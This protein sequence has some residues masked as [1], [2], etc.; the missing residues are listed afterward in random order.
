MR[1]RKRMAGE[2]ARDEPISDSVVKFKVNVYFTL[3]DTLVGELRSRFS[4]FQTM[5]VPFKCLMPGHLH[6][7]EGFDNLASMYED[8]VDK[9]IANAEYSQ[10]CHF[11]DITPEFVDDPP[12]IV[13][14]MLHMINRWDICNAF[15]NLTIL[16]R[17]LGTIAISSATS[18]RSFSRLKLTKTYLRSTMTEERLS[19]LAIL[20]IER[21]FSEQVDFDAVIDTFSQMSVRRMELQ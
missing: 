16:Y 19:S 5:V 15:P 2:M 11:Y 20:S 6:D 8:D 1:R 4:D 13:Q 7:S 3:Y 12:K 21:D 10:F 9:D 18:E 17:I 14:K